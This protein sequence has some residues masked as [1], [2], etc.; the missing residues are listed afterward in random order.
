MGY[1]GFWHAKHL[2]HTHNPGIIT[3]CKLLL[4]HHLYYILQKSYTSVLYRSNPYPPKCGHSR[5]GGVVGLRIGE[6][7]LSLQLPKRLKPK[8]DDLLLKLSSCCKNNNCRIKCLE[9]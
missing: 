8:I 6:G 3:I 7:A 5:G 2:I 9:G 1:T 4:L